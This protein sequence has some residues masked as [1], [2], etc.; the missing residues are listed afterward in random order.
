MNTQEF[1]KHFDAVVERSRNVLINKRNEYANNQSVFN[2]FDQATGLSFHETNVSVA[3]EYAVKHLQSLKDIIKKVESNIDQS[4]TPE[5]I[6]EK[7]GDI[8]NYMILIEG[9]LKERCETREEL[10]F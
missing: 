10:P 5:L 7:M 2:N 6:N 3:W 4:I 9:M 1:N 8:I